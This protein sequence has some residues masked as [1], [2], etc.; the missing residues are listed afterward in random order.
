MLEMSARTLNLGSNLGPVRAIKRAIVDGFGNVSGIDFIG[1][2]EI[3]DGA[4]DFQ[5][6]IVGSRGEPQTGHGTFQHRLAFGVNATVKTNQTR[7]HRGIR[8]NS[9]GGESLALPLARFDNAL[10]NRT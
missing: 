5:D 4:A 8:E 6:A 9:L 1:V 10:S 3:G 7:R 2:F